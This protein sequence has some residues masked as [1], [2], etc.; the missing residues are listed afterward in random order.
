[1]FPITDSQADCCP[2]RG[3]S[4]SPRRRLAGHTERMSAPEEALP[5]PPATYDANDS[6]SSVSANILASP[7][8]RRPEQQHL[9]RVDVALGHL[10][11]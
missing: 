9:R 3:Q 5:L 2:A 8:C 4:F 10:R 1:M 11:L 6:R 7:L